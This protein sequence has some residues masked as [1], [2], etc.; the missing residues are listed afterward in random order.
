M[1]IRQAMVNGALADVRVGAT[2]EAIAGALMPQK[3]E[4]VLEA[5]GG[6]LLPGLHDHHIHLY[7]SA[8]AYSSLDCHVGAVEP[9]LGRQRLAERLAAFP[10]R[11]WIRGINY[12]EQQLGELDRWMLDDLCSHRPLRIQHRSGKVWVCNSLAL[13]L[14]GFE[15]GEHLEGVELDT[16]NRLTGRIVRNDALMAQRLQQI[17]ESSAADIGFLSRDLARLGIVGVTDTSASNNAASAANFNR[18]HQQGTLLQR[19]EVMGA[20]D[21][22]AGY[23]KILL[24]EDRLPPL[25]QLIGRI[26]AAREKG[27]NIAFHCVTHL[28]L[29]FALAALDDA[30]PPALGFD[31]IEHGAMVN[32]DMAQ[33]L[34][35][36]GMPVIT[37]PGFLYA[38]GDQY[39]QDLNA[40]EQSDLYRYRG[41]VAR[42]VAVVASS[43]G[44]YGPIDPW[45]VV[46]CAVNRRTLGGDV[47]TPWEKAEPEEA[48]CG[49]LTPSSQ[50]NR[51]RS[52]R[53]CSGIELGMVGDVCLLKDQWRDV[54]HCPESVTV[55]ATVI[56]GSVVYDSAQS[57]AGAV[58]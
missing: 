54:R 6:E 24:D 9:H 1:L 5:E 35:Q 38:K 18:L 55:R 48:L 20:D 19:V 23:L 40:A 15:R 2:V 39:L 31:R 44:P 21:L 37:Q 33:R 52:F 51:A 27:R 50:L 34:A 49:Y 32:D 3:G 12:H 28:E 10:G 4:R 53:Q 30:A 8:A 41:L 13:S 25:D 7:A 22:D 58:N 26:N 57:S 42:G 45:Q 14:L 46:C 29:V 43:D 36:M 11:G 56:G 16:K 17:G 47:V